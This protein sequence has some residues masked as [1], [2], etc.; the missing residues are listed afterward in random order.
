[1]LQA[2]PVH[3]YLWNGDTAASWPGDTAVPLTGVVGWRY[4]MKSKRLTLMGVVVGWGTLPGQQHNHNGGTQARKLWGRPARA[5]ESRTSPPS[6]RHVMDRL[7]GAGKSYKW[8]Q[9]MSWGYHGLVEGGYAWR[10]PC[11]A[12]RLVGVF[13]GTMSLMQALDC[14]EVFAVPGE[15]P[16]ALTRTSSG[17]CSYLCFG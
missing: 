2:S 10:T 14:T 1:M 15:I 3:C 4:A 9:S 13:R 16:L 8:I 6:G 17:Y 11:G 7:A 5:W 12:A